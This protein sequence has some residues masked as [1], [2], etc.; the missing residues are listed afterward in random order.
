M[1]KDADTRA[2]IDM[3]S[4]VRKPL[5]FGC[6]MFYHYQTIYC[7]STRPGLCAGTY[8]WS[9][10]AM[11]QTAIVDPQTGRD[12]YHRKCFTNRASNS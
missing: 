2:W 9:E 6:T 10:P 4:F 7:D 11:I 12:E 5:D 3:M 8:L 1:G